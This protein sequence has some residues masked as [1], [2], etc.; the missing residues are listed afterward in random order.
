MDK[1]G[2][3]LSLN[4]SMVMR[5]IWMSRSTTQ[6]DLARNLELNPST[7]SRIIARLEETGLIQ[8]RNMESANM[9]VG[10]RP[11]A[12]SI[13]TSFGYILGI[14]IQPDTFHAVGIDL[15]GTILFKISDTLPAQ[16]GIPES[17]TLVLK[18]LQHECSKQKSP[19]IGISLGL[20]GLID[21][22]NGI[23][24]R[25]NPLDVSEPLDFVSLVREHIDL[26]IFIENDANCC[27]W[28]ELALAGHQRSQNMIYVLGEFRHPRKNKLDD[29]TL[30]VGIGIVINGSVYHGSHYAS[31]EFQSILWKEKNSSQ[32]S[33]S[34][35]E[36]RDALANR[37][38]R[39]GII[40]ELAQHIGYTANILDV[41]HIYI[42]GNIVEEKDT[43]EP[44]FL[45][46]IN[47][48]N[49][50]DLPAQSRIEF[51]QMG[52]YAV[53][54]GAAAMFLEHLFAIPSDERNS[55]KTYLGVH[56]LKQI[57]K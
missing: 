40:Q 50:Y 33:F 3:V 32:F 6:T 34:D 46:E 39:K 53:A 2:D 11:K 16:T 42:G 14:E 43:I 21:P 18:M 54:H 30:A 19:L 41:S 47:R 12:V 28:G 27:C 45:E 7:V 24:Q 20:P 23:I 37:S 35:D 48:N 51:S 44:M 13:D 26:P 1:K 10:R 8:S 9:G 17:F 49:S 29:V 31:G 36:I 38:A 25:S 52:E 55:P 5:D 4:T 22:Y 15:N 57:R 56:L